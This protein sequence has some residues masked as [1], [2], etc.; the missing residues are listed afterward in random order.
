MPIRK[1][2]FDVDGTLIDSKLDIIN[3]QLY[4]LQYYGFS[5]VP[6]NEIEPFYGKPVHELMA[7]YLPAE[8]H[9]L[10][11]EAV[12][13]YRSHYRDH[14]FDTT[15]LFS[16]VKETLKELTALGFQCATATTKST[17]STQTILE[18]FEIARYFV[19]IQGTDE[20]MLYKP[21][22][23][24]INKILQNQN[25]NFIETI[26]IGDSLS[27]IQAGKSAGIKTCG[28]TYGAATNEEISK[29]NPDFLIHN[30]SEILPLAARIAA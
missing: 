8:K 16:D 5:N 30:F 2:I 7:M 24:I 13:I 6:A 10:L 26:I 4:M 9:Y 28:V 1:I 11:P 3:S 14:W 15:T 29:L 25:W 20:G 27:D 18:H 12:E 19:Q 23:F 21:D 17:H 22:P